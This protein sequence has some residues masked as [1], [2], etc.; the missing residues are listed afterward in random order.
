MSN[1]TNKITPKGIM[2]MK[3]DIKRIA[4]ALMP[5]YQQHILCLNKQENP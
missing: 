3:E 5:E 2:N 4:Q 1:P